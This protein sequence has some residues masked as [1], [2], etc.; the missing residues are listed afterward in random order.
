M[1]GSGAED[2][3]DYAALRQELENTPSRSLI[4]DS[5]SEFGSGLSLQG[6]DDVVEFYLA[7]RGSEQILESSVQPSEFSESP[8][9]GRSF[10]FAKDTPIRQ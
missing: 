1:E 3:V 6:R 2:K 8:I 4:K 10:D 5:A 7:R 9:K